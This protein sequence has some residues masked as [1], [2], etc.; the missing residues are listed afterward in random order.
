[1]SEARAVL[2]EPNPHTPPYQSGYFNYEFTLQ[3]GHMKN[4]K[5]YKLSQKIFLVLSF[6]KIILQK[7]RMI[8]S[9]LR[10]HV[11]PCPKHNHDG[12]K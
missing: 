3:V 2:P 10:H 6:F 11:S 1:M 5:F 7:K 9:V 4:G 8:K 12:S